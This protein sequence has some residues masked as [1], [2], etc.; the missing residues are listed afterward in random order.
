M[1]KL[2]NREVERT[3]NRAELR[4][5]IQRIDE[6]LNIMDRYAADLAMAE[7]G[8][9]ASM[10]SRDREHKDEYLHSVPRPMKHRR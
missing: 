2:I 8:I 10:R 7:Y 9:Q 3:S 4:K 5:G 1:T 6:D